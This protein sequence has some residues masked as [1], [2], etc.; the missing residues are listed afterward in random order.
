LYRWEGKHIP[1]QD[2]HNCL[3]SVQDASC[4]GAWFPENLILVQT[5]SCTSTKYSR[6][7]PA[8][9]CTGSLAYAPVHEIQTSFTSSKTLLHRFKNLFY[10]I[11]FVWCVLQKTF[12]KNH[13]DNILPLSNPITLTYFLHHTKHRGDACTYN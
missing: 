6:V 11:L 13:L 5:Y 12:Y 1:V 7:S 3:V 9:F 4:T 2:F 8:W 10:M